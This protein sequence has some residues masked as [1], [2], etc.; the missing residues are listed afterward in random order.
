MLS[1]RFYETIPA[2]GEAMKT[3]I[4][5]VFL[6]I[7][8]FT[9]T[10][11][12]QTADIGKSVLQDNKKNN[13]GKPLLTFAKPEQMFKILP[14]K[15]LYLQTD[16]KDAFT[17]KVSPD[18]KTI[19]LIYPKTEEKPEREYLYNVLAVGKFFIRTQIA[20]EKRLTA[21]GKP[22]VW[23]FLFISDD[24][25][26]WHRTDWEGLKS[27]APIKRCQEKVPPLE[28]LE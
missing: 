1:A 22:V 10:V 11:M 19:I 2:G 18:L 12:A 24:D 6:L 27:T 14:G 3:R 21:D 17:I 7:C 28:I 8:A 5:F 25:L 15:W 9:L 4:S 20:D 23:D 26:L 13:K 16:C